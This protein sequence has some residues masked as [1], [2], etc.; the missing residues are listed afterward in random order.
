[1]SARSSL[2]RLWLLAIWGACAAGKAGPAGPTRSSLDGPGPGIHQ[3][4]LSLPGGQT[5]RYT[6]A[7]PEAYRA[8]ARRR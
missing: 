2:L 4:T 1:M 3:Q 8:T 5:L 6:L 7:I